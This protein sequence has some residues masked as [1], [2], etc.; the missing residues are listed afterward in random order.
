V[1]EYGDRVRAHF[2]DEALTFDAH[3][4][5]APAGFIDRMVDRAFRTKRLTRRLDL[6]LEACREASSVLEVGSGSGRVAVAIARANPDIHITGIDFSKEMNELARTLVARAGVSDR[7]EFVYGDFLT[8]D[9]A[10]HSFDVVVAPGVFDYIRLPGP[11]LRRL[12]DLSSGRVGGSFPA[13][14]RALTPVRW[15][16][17]RAQGCPVGFY[18]RGELEAMAEATG[19]RV[20]RLDHIGSWIAGYYWLVLDAA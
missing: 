4:D 17:L 12:C 9:F 2:E 5:A 6:V 14:Y 7:C 16:R 13:R 11:A 8:H 20:D 10:L 3:Y 19:A 1:D 18:T 15:A